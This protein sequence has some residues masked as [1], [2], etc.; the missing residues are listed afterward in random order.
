MRKG[1]SLIELLITIGIVAVLG[2]IGTMNLVNYRSRNILDLQTQEIVATLRDAQSRSISQEN[3]RPWGIHFENPSS[4]SD[5]YSLFASSTYNSSDINSTTTLNSAVVFLDPSAGGSKNV[6]FSA[7]T[8]LPSAADS[9]AIALKANNSVSSTITINAIGQIQIGSLTISGP[10]VTTQAATNIQ[11]TTATLNGTITNEGSAST[12][13]VGFDYGLTTDYGSQI[14]SAWLGG[15]GSFSQGVSGLTGST[16]YHFRAKA[17]SSTGL[18]GYGGDQSFTTTASGLACLITTVC[19]DTTIFKLSATTNAHAEMPSQANYTK[20][21]CCS[22]TGLGTSCSGNYD[23]V[24]KLSGL[25]NA[26]VEKKT[27]ANYANSACISVTSGTVLCDY[28]TDCSLLGADYTCL[29]SISGDTNAH[30]GDCN[31]YATKVCCKISNP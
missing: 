20:Y 4:D 23:T 21:V 16:L 24:L 6:N 11:A 10:T 31:A 15:T 22:G 14:T 5:Y 19:S 12:T 17:Y 1:F 2:T 25:T 3:G 9:L 13:V 26:H 7:V 29:A 8:G 30:V 27:Q 28:S 18:W